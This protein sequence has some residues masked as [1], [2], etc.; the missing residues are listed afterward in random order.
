MFYTSV[1]SEIRIPPQIADSS[2]R[3]WSMVRLTSRMPYCLVYGI[4]DNPDEDR[5]MY[6]TIMCANLGEVVAM[7]SASE[8]ETRQIAL[9]TPGDPNEMAGWHMETITEIW[10]ASEPG[11]GL[12]ATAVL[13]VSDSGTRHVESRLD[14][15]EAELTNLRK[16]FPSG[17][18]RAGE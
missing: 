6:V 18:Q 16:V 1:D 11:L 5:R 8:F 9:I 10:S 14:T 15:K 13:Y 17:E 2:L 4:V 7:A 3:C 12:D